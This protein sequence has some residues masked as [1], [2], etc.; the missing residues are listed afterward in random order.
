VKREIT[1]IVTPGTATDANLLRSHENNYLA[2]AAARNARRV[3]HVD[4]STGEFRV[5]EMAGRGSAAL[6][7]PGAREV[8]FPRGAAAEGG[9]PELPASACARTW[10]LGLR[11]RLRRPNLKE[12]FQLLTLDGC[13]LAGRPLAVCAAGAILHYVRETQRAALDHLDRPA[14]YE[15]SETMVLDAVTVRN[16]ELVEPLFAGDAAR[17]TLLGVL[18]QTRTGMGG[19]AAA[20]AA[21]APS[22]DRKRSKRGWMRWRSWRADHPRARTCARRSAACWISSAC[23]RRP[24]GTPG[25]AICWRSAVRWPRFRRSSVLD[26]TRDVRTAAAICDRLDE[27]AEVRDRI[28]APSPTSRR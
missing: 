26:L 3:A 16:L 19:A 14:H 17:S 11:S 13:G 24:L 21:A 25:R 4:V 18:D 9:P 10:R 28:L 23:W 6:E 8:L 7:Q 2:A 22:M 20:A 5:T 1:R 27:V 15:R 12:H